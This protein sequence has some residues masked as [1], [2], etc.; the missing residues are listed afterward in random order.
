MRRRDHLGIIHGL[1]D[2]GLY[3]PLV[4]GCGPDESLRFSRKCRHERISDWQWHLGSEQLTR[5]WDS[6]EK[7]VLLPVSI[8]PVEW[9]I[10]NHDRLLSD[11]HIVPL[12]ALAAFEIANDKVRLADLAQRAGL[13]VPPLVD[14]ADAAE[15]NAWRLPYPVL[16]K[17][18]SGFGGSGIV[19]FETLR[20]LSE[21]LAGMTSKQN[22][23]V[24]SLIEGR[25][26]SCG[27]YCH[28]GNVLASVT[29]VPLARDSL[30]SLHFDQGDRRSARDGRRRATDAGTAVERNCQYRS[31]SVA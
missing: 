9:A 17:P 24:Q 12:P 1:A 7:A 14:L 16:L 18:R 27:V 4:V 3:E 26:V 13:P 23:F 2:T 25:D 6:S 15:S 10:R 22:Y 21:Q 29:Y 11:W 30:R 31:Y 19:A 5:P 20:Q 28:D 8:R